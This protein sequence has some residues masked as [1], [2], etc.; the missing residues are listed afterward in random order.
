MT[1]EEQHEFENFYN[2]ILDKTLKNELHWSVD[3]DR[4][5]YK[6]YVIESLTLALYKRKLF[7]RWGYYSHYLY[8][9]WREAYKLK[10]AIQRQDKN[11]EVRK[12][13]SDIDRIR[14]SMN[15]E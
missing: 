15:R 10:K 3:Y 2:E 8:L 5:R 6:V 12:I 14:F 9:T 11:T 13:L 4:G 7:T 1:N